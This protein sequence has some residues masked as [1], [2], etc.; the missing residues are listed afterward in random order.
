MAAWIVVS[1]HPAF[2]APAFRLRSAGVENGVIGNAYGCATAID[3]TY[4]KPSLP[5]AWSGAPAGTTSFDV[6]MADVGG[7]GGEG[8]GWVHWQLRGLPGGVSAL[9]E[10]ASASVGHGH[11]PK[12]AQ[13]LA[14]GWGDKGYGGPCPPHPP[15]SYRITVTA[16]TGDKVL[17]DA[18]LTVAF[19][20]GT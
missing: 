14:N 18:T 9:Q 4:K 7:A 12:G 13:E 6:L 19:R 1:A 2:G 15:H 8:K 3:K 10:G 17:G 5:L 16:K 11:L 20:R